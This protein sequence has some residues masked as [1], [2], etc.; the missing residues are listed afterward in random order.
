LIHEACWN[1]FAEVVKI[2]VENGVDSREENEDGK[3]PLQVAIENS[4]TEVVRYLKSI[5]V[6][7]EDK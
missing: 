5:E 1:G 3:T 4:R 7:G 2:L 6:S